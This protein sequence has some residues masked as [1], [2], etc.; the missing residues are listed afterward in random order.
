ME[1]LHVEGEATHNDP[2]S[3]GW[4]TRGIIPELLLELL[5]RI[6]IE[7]LD[8]HIDIPSPRPP[9]V[10]PTGPIRLRSSRPGP[11]RLSALM[12]IWVFPSNPR[13]PASPPPPLA[14]RR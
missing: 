5:F 6:R 1:E 10:E 9:W 8:R 4:H 3:C 12:S 7:L 14:I 11:R 13:F 2:E